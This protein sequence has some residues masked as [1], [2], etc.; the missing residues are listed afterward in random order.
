[1]GQPDGGAPKGEVLDFKSAK[2]T[3]PIISNEKSDFVRLLQ[4]SKLMA[5]SRFYLD[6]IDCSDPSSEASKLADLSSSLVRSFEKY[7][8]TPNDALLVG[9][10]A[11]LEY[12]LGRREICLGNSEEA[13]L[14]LRSAFTRNEFQGHTKFYR[15]D[16]PALK[17]LL[18]SYADET[19]NTNIKTF[20][21]FIETSKLKISVKSDA[22]AAKFGAG[23]S[24]RALKVLLD[25]EAPQLSPDILQTIFND[26]IQESKHTTIELISLAETAKALSVKYPTLN[27][28]VLTKILLKRS[29]K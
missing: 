14:L 8:F 28:S 2:D 10:L 4:L 16:F 23:S 7:K 13:K 3:L 15:N 9:S 22:F 26:A 1:M 20:S 27:P 18:L 6:L 19:T 12:C 25:E 5:N 11:D 29:H 21:E 17:Y 24:S